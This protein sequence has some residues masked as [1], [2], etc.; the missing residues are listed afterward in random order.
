MSTT[1]SERSSWTSPGSDGSAK[2][3]YDS[4]RYALR[5][6]ISK[7]GVEVF[8][9]GSYANSTNI[10]ADSDVDIVVMTTETFQGSV[11]RL[12]AARKT[13]FDSLPE[14]TY[15]TKD[16]RHDVLVAL[17]SYYGQSRV[18]PKN[19]CIRV[20]KSDGY[21]DADVV[22]ALQYRWY[23]NPES[24]ISTGYVEGI[25]IQPLSGLR[26]INFPKEHIKNGVSKNAVCSGRFKETVRQVKR[27][28][29]RAVDLG[30][31][32][33]GEAPGYLLECL[34]YNV[35]SSEFISDDAERLRKVALWLKYADKGLFLS[36]CRIQH[37]FVDD[38][39]NFSVDQTNRIAD[40][41]W[42]AS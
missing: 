36:V 23:P 12:S 15:D 32:R 19:K 33:E 7:R 37:L 2:K 28:R 13:Q 30:L 17:Y 38:P 21:V 14:A 20:D 3:T 11:S 24:D 29:N 35:P 4:V 10:R 16:L 34:T 22:C 8:L 39:G 9:Q 25:S 42:E 31:L 6:V 40:A 1:A 27:L 26:I 18:H 5:D 41:L